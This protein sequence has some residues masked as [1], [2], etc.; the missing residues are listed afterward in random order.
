[1][2][3]FTKQVKSK[4]KGFFSIVILIDMMG[5]VVHVLLICQPVPL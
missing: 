1:M 4:N 2:V 3:P 5:K